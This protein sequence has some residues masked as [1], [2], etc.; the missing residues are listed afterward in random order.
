MCVAVH[1]CG[2]NG[3]NTAIGLLLTVQL[4]S[5]LRKG[6]E[7]FAEK[8]AILPKWCFTSSIKQQTFGK[9]VS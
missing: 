6:G 4:V 3:K 8:G 5:F 9:A 2:E 1:I 7:G